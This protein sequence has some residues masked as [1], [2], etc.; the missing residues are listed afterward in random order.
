MI[1]ADSAAFADDKNM[2]NLVLATRHLHK[3][4]VGRVKG[5]R[6]GRRSGT[7]EYRWKLARW[8]LPKLKL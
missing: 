5:V 3:V 2:K 8:N 6:Q 4:E 7:Q 1:K